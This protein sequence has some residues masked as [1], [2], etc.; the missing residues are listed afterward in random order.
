VSA[1]N[2]LASLA[3][4]AF[5]GLIDPA[6]RDDDAADESPWPE[7]LSGEAGSKL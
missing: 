5:G 4:W 7:S 6:T 2:F 3:R 1:L